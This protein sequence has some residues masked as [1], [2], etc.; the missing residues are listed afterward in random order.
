M[1]GAV[2]KTVDVFKASGGSNPPLSANSTSMKRFKEKMNYFNLLKKS[3]N[4]YKVTR[5]IKQTITQIRKKYALDKY[6]AKKALIAAPFGQKHFDECVVGLTESK[7]VLQLAN[8]GEILV[9]IVT[10]EDM[11][12]GVCP[13]WLKIV[14]INKIPKWPVADIYQ[15]RFIKWAI[16]FLFK[17][18]Q[19]SIYIDSN[20]IITNNA[21]KLLNIFDI[22]R[23][24]DFFVTTHVI[25]KGWQDEFNAILNHRFLDFE[26]L[27][28]Q[29]MLFQE[30]NIPIKGTVFENGFIGRVHDSK[31]NVLNQDVLNQLSEYSERDQLAL[32]Y[33]VFKRN[34][35]L[36]RFPEGEIL[37]VNHVDSINPNTICFVV[38]CHRDKF[39]SIHKEPF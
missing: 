22:T 23:Q 1:N 15:N 33:A 25:R 11:A 36:S 26:K 12:I 21:N 20:F 3:V 17:N 4:S 38:N 9:I 14:Q 27:Q 24:H 6:K 8:R 29:K 5:Q 7:A 2:S 32:I 34:I 19:C 39:S 30:L 28:K 13:K 31:Y 10:S 16:P 35:I 37:F 18:I